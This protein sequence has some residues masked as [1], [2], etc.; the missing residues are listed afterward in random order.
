MGGGGQQQASPPQL[1]VGQTLALNQGQ[2]DL[3]TQNA[4]TV[5]RELGD[6]SRR[7]SGLNT[8]YGLN[9]LT[10]PRETLSAAGRQRARDIR[11]QALGDINDNTGLSADERQRRIDQVEAAYQRE[12]AKVTGDDFRPMEDLQRAFRTEF[13]QRDDL[14]ND[15]KGARASSSEYRRAQTALGR[16][17]QAQTVGQR[18]AATSRAQAAQATTAQGRAASMGNVANVQAGQVAASRMGNFGAAQSRNIGAGQVGAG[19]LGDTLMGRAQQMAQSTGRLSA[20]AER[21][22][23]QAARSGMAA[24]GM[25]TGSAGLATEML[26][27][28]RFARQR[29]FEDLGFAQGVQGQDLTRQFQNVGNR[30]AADQNNQSASMQAELANLQARYN[31]A[32]QSGN[33][34]QAAAIQNQEAGLRASLANQQ[35]Q[36]NTGQFNAGNQQTMNMANMAALNQGSQF[37]AAN[38]QQANMANMQSANQMAQFNTALGADAD[39]YN[40]GQR[41]AVNRYNLGLLGTSAAMADQERARQL[42]TQQDIYNFQ[43]QTNPRLML[44]GLGSPFAN[45]TQPALSAVSGITGNVNPIYTGGQFSGGGFNM[46]GAAMGGASGALSGAAMGAMMGAPAGGIGAVPGALIGGVLGGGLGAF[47]GGYSD[48]RMKTDIKKIDGPTN[49]IG[50]PSYEYRYKGEKK[51][52]RGVMAQDVQKVLPEAVAEVDYKGKK[53]LAIKPMVIGAALAE[54]LAADTKPVAL[55]S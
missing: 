20:D 13:G 21:D 29:Q 27:R 49:V 32:A 19:A 11:Q 45:M 48:K 2:I 17:V 25:A 3:L 33:W 6:I 14:V 18:T 9:L 24:R 38:Q 16:G 8:L 36:F 37:N 54:H 46:G 31:A 44:A 12:L 4:P 43:M 42:G 52:R 10:D 23:V 35:T 39:R 51:K 34:Q 28:D 55:A 50:I 26:N 22:A 15:M 30:L 53:R 7:E 40:A 47:G 5:A 1:N 41:D